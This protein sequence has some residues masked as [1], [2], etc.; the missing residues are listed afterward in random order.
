M[1]DYVASFAKKDFTTDERAISD[2]YVE[3]I[4]SCLREDTDGVLTFFYLDP[5][6]RRCYFGHENDFGYVMKA[7]CRSIRRHRDTRCQGDA[8]LS[9][10]LARVEEYFKSEGCWTDS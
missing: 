7:A 3:I 9:E 10:R 8:H 4:H 5:L 1:V 2:A 6:F